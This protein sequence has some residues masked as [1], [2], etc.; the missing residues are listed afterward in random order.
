[1]RDGLLS[2]LSCVVYRLVIFP[3]SLDF[4]SMTGG[5]ECIFCLSYLFGLHLVRPST[6]VVSETCTYQV[7]SIIQ[8]R[9][10]T[11]AYSFWITNVV[12]A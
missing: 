2:A 10:Q 7:Q 12:Q 11:H 4:T 6:K 1:M 5:I 3:T 9:S 8:G